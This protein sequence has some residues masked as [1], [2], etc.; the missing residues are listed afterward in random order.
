M[1]IT[2]TGT[3]GVP[4]SAV[5]YS[6]GDGGKKKLSQMSISCKIQII[7]VGCNGYGK[8]K[9]PRYDIST[10]YGETGTTVNRYEYPCPEC[11]GKGWKE[12]DEI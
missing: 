11:G 1:S 2:N 3:D 4:G 9:A 7:C 6:I 5:V 10:G 8:T 12:T